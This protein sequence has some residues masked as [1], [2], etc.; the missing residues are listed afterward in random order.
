MDRG[1][2]TWG[3]EIGSDGG[4]ATGKKGKQSHT[5]GW[6]TAEQRR[7]PGAAQVGGR[8]LKWGLG[9]KAHQC[10]GGKMGRELAEETSRA[11]VDKAM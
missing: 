9:E 11:Q 7:G 2:G 5:T 6:V 1:S 3:K 8:M 4:D 10:A